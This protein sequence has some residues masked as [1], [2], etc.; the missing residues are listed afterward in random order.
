MFLICY[1]LW[2]KVYAELKTVNLFIFGFL[3][4][5]SVSEVVNAPLKQHNTLTEGKIHFECESFYTPKGGSPNV[6]ILLPFLDWNKAG[7]FKF[8]TGAGHT[9]THIHEAFLP[10]NTWLG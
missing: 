6:T 4:R 5:I 1:S 8:E 2:I 7:G 10:Y 3:L 9:E